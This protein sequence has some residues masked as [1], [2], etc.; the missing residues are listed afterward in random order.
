MLNRREWPLLEEL[1]DPGKGGES[2]PPPEEEGVE[3]P[4]TVP[5]DVLPEG[6]RDKSPAEV[7]FL[8][9]RMSEGV[10]TSNETS[11]E[12]RQRLAQLEEN[13]RNPPKPVEPDPDDDI[14]DEELIVKDP[15]KAVMRILKKRGMVDQFAQMGSQ[16]GETVLITVGAKIPG[17]DEYE[18][19]VRKLLRESNSP[20]DE[21]HIKGALKMVIGDRVLEERAKNS[22]KAGSLET[23]K[24]D[25]DGEK[26]FSPLE[27]LEK[28]IF[29]A[30][31]M[32]RETYERLK[33][34]DY[35]PVK[36]PT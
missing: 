22:R 17:F 23:P 16:V 34:D 28:D 6:L 1:E 14:P 21:A 19:D 36:V 5:V 7:K 25:S 10:I 24:D 26:K 18:Q 32:D 35:I 27:G 29:E 30:S 3:T 15:D 31:N 2:D 4:R 33:T 12:L 8:L 9:E 20:I 11:K 13:L